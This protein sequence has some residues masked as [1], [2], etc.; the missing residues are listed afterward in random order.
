MRLTVALALATTG[1]GLLRA[2]TAAEAVADGV[3][4]LVY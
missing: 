4:A 3:T 1:C 2:P